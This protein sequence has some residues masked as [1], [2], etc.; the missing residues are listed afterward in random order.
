MIAW[1]C[2]LRHDFV[3]VHLADNELSRR[4]GDQVRN[5]LKHHPGPWRTIYRMR[6]VLPSAPFQFTLSLSPFIRIR[7]NAQPGVEDGRF[8]RANC[9]DALPRASGIRINCGGIPRH[10]TTPISTPWPNAQ[11]PHNGLISSG[12]NRGG[13]IFDCASFLSLMDFDLYDFDRTPARK[14]PEPNHPALPPNCFRVANRLER[15]AVVA[16]QYPVTTLRPRSS[17][18]SLTG[19]VESSSD[20]RLNSTSPNRRVAVYCSASCGWLKSFFS[21]VSIQRSA[22]VAILRK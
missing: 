7:C 8:G 5:E 12:A 2:V 19:H 3:R 10:S 1:C 6:S 18:Q 11:L 20:C 13:L 17:V 16:H 22:D 14:S 4:A 21:G 15:N 9:N